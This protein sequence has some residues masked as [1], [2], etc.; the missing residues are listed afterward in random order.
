MSKPK[1]I[2]EITYEVVIDV[3]KADRAT[4]R[5][6][7]VD[8]AGFESTFRAAQAKAKAALSQLVAEIISNSV[9]KDGAVWVKKPD[10]HFQWKTGV[11]VVAEADLRQAARERG[12]DV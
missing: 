2:D 10:G 5:W 9:H 1:T 3:A 8:N 11:P 6:F 4:R 7:G 12:F